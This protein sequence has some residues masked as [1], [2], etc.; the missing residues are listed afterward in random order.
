MIYYTAVIHKR[1]TAVEILHIPIIIS[2][3]Y[4]IILKGWNLAS[5]VLMLFYTGKRNKFD[6]WPK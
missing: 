2:V 1:A 6:Y 5:F 4:G 3:I